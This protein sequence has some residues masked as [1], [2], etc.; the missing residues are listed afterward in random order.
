MRTGISWSNLHKGTGGWHV[1][2][3]FSARRDSYRSAL[4]SWKDRSLPSGGPDAS[5]MDSWRTVWCSRMSIS[6]T[7][8]NRP[9]TS[10][11]GVR[12]AHQLGERRPVPGEK[13]G[14]ETLIRLRAPFV[15]TNDVVK[16]ARD[17]NLKL[18]LPLSVRSPPKMRTS[19]SPSLAARSTYVY[20]SADDVTV[21]LLVEKGPVNIWGCGSGANLVT[22]SCVTD[23][24]RF[25]SCCR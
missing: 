20:V 17:T 14:S 23:I 2:R 4:T 10:R 25:T 9:V 18:R 16:R 1:S 6:G 21:Y 7:V 3:A 5:I 11:R 22:A 24:R 13:P 12:G 19:R 15:E 8:R